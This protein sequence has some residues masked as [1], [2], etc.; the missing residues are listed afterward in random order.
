MELIPNCACRST[1]TW[2]NTY[3]RILYYLLLPIDY[4]AW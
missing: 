1:V 4:D 3:L 2:R